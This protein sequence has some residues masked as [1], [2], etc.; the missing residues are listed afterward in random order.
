MVR[1]KKLLNE[2]RT[3]PS[4]A[5]L[6]L[7][8]FRE[9]RRISLEDVVEKTKISVRFLLAIEAGEYYR[10]PGGIF[11]TSYLRQYARAIGHSEQPLLDDYHLQMTSAL[12]LDEE[13]RRNSIFSRW[14]DLAAHIRP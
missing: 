11:N 4:A 6:R 8:E 14:F 3:R 1:E 7:A 10:L 13:P 5:P 2:W 9:S 12:V